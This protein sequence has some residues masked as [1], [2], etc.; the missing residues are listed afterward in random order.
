MIN[1]ILVICVGNICRSPLAQVMLDNTLPG[2]DV[3]SAGLSAMVDYPA[4]KKMQQAAL[5]YGVDLSDHRA[6]Q[7]SKTLME[8]ADLIFVMSEGQMNY[9]KEQY[10]HLGGRVLL[11]SHFSP[12]GLKGVSVAD[13]YQQASSLFVECAKQISF[14]V[15]AIAK[16][17]IAQIR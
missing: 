4:D 17:L 12:V 2:V 10:P 13:P 8:S 5:Q 15:D 3:D 9:L 1:R 6:K 16:A 7:V 11:L 14:H